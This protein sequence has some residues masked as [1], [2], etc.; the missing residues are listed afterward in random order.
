MGSGKSAP[1]G[2]ETFADW[3]EMFMKN[4]YSSVHIIKSAE[5]ELEKT[6]GNIV[7]ISSIAGIEALGA[8]ITYS[9]AK[10]ALNSFVK[11]ISKP[12]AQKKIRINVVAPG[13]IL[14]K[15]STWDKK[16]KVNKK[17]VNEMLESNVAM[18]RFGKPEEVAGLVTFLVSSHASFITG[19]L[20][21]IDGGQLR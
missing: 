19:S 3:Q 2:E 9:V 14:F 6:S 5:K 10:A 12:L 18:K 4:F 7:C 1:P 8:P 17:K 16:I 13:N 20:F 15:D 21:V 11:N